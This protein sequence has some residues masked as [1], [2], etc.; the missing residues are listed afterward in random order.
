MSLPL[1]IVATNGPAAY[2]WLASSPLMFWSLFGWVM[3]VG[4]L[5]PVP[6]F[7]LGCD[8]QFP[9]AIPAGDLVDMLIVNSADEFLGLM[10]RKRHWI[11]SS[12]VSKPTF[13]MFCCHL[14]QSAISPKYL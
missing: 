8:S 12:V 11:S 9:I 3:D 5:S 1:A 14:Q 10:S 13:F 7:T 4:T 2:A 6:S